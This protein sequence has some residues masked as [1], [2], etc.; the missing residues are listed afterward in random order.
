M[1]LL[2]LALGWSPTRFGISCNHFEIHV[3]CTLHVH[4][5]VHVRCVCIEPTYTCTCTG[6]VVFC[7]HVH[8]QAPLWVRLHPVATP[9]A[10]LPP[11]HSGT[12]GHPPEHPQKHLLEHRRLGDITVSWMH[13]LDMRL[14]HQ[15][16]YQSKNFMFGIGEGWLQ[17]VRVCVRPKS[18]VIASYRG[19]ACSLSLLSLSLSLPL[20]LSLSLDLSL[21]F[22]QC[23]RRRP[24]ICDHLGIH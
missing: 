13:R 15:I 16:W 8:V 2:E 20:S 24:G 3:Q 23:P 11:C 17:F 21:P 9:P 12:S 10:T 5:H 7:V 14:I 6:I 18:F 22:S 19:C 4:V 1:Y